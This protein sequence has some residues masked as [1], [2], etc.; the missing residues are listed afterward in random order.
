[1]S[2]KSAAGVQVT[3]TARQPSLAAMQVEA[4]LTK[5]AR[6]G[7]EREAVN[8]MTYSELD[9]AASAVAGTWHALGMRPGERVALA[10]PPGADFVVALHACWRLGCAVVPLDLRAP[11]PP[12][13]GAQQNVQELPRRRDLR[14]PPLHNPPPAAA[15]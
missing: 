12:R 1:M 7:P 9:A 5:V 3:G 10:L 6:T 8:G 14:A 2:S 11:D 15:R 13:A 4:W